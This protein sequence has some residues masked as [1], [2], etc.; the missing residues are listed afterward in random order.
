MARCQRTG[1]SGRV[2]AAIGWPN[3]EGEG[4]AVQMGVQEPR[5]TSQRETLVA[6]QAPRIAI[7]GSRLRCVADDGG[8]VCV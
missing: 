5:G 4:G 8:G 3:R 7:V 1:V 2:E 6:S